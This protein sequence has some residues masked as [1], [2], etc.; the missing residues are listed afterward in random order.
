MYSKNEQIEVEIVDIT[1]EG[2]GVGKTSDF[3]WF[4][5]DTIPGDTVKA[6]VMKIKKSYGYARLIEIVIPSENRVK[7]VCKVARSCGGCTLQA[8]S[9]PAQLEFKRNKVK[10]AIERIGSFSNIIIEPVIGM[11]NPWR[12]RNKAVIPIGTD[13]SGN[14]VAG[15][16]AAHSHDIIDIDD[17]MICFEENSKIISMAKT[18]Y[19][20]GLSHI[21]IRKGFKTNQIMSC[22]VSNIENNSIP[23]GDIIPISGSNYIEDYIGKLKFKISPRSFFQV[24]PVQVEKLYG[25]VLEFANLTGSEIV[26]DL[27]CGIGTITLSLAKYSKKVFGVEVIED[28]IK[29]ATENA[30]QNGI[31]NVQF[32][33]GKVEEVLNNESFEIPDVVV[34]DPPRKGCDEETL[35]TILQL[36]PQ[37]VVYV[38]CNPATLARDL[39]LLC[40]EKYIIKIIQPVDMFPQTTHVESVVKLE[41]KDVKSKD[42]IEI[43]IDAEDYYRIKNKGNNKF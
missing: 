38:S 3:V 27:Y 35:K 11:D 7:P 14:V 41:R 42:Y 20:D 37:R 16:Y 32:Y 21:L 28:A 25:K 10:N 19:S 8:M 17:C 12:Y 18:L 24:N 5:K 29:D 4:I 33:T 39:K 15:Y 30:E 31:R 43:G 23:S 13:K 36:E 40:A 9:Y 2:A 6:S 26:W 22:F 34:V 1:D